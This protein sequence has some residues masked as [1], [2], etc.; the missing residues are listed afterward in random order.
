MTIENVEGIVST[1]NKIKVTLDEKV[2]M[3][4]VSIEDDYETKMDPATNAGPE[5]AD[6]TD[7]AILNVT[8][9][10]LWTEEQ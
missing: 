9:T 5:I 8:S 6:K 1:S 2:V 10:F 7:R 3:T 4:D